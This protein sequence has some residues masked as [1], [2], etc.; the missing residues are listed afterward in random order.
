MYICIYVYMYICIYVS[1]T[2][3]RGTQWCVHR[4]SD[5]SVGRG[6]W[7]CLREPHP[8]SRAISEVRRDSLR[9]PFFDRFFLTEKINQGHPKPAKRVP[10]G[11]PLV[12]ISGHFGGT[13]G[14]L[15]T[16]VSCTRNHRFHGCRGSPETSCAA[17]CA[18][19]FSTW[20]PQ[21]FFNDFGPNRSKK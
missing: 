12:V 18:Q 7:N 11:Y 15:R 6:L 21:R 10:K 14:N 20:L 5:G 8:L 19:C 16:M 13:S 1:A 2:V 4:V 9:D 3:P 17:L